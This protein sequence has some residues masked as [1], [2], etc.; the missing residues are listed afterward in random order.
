MKQ[1]WTQVLS[2]IQY[3]VIKIQHA[4][5]SGIIDFPTKYCLSTSAGSKCNFWNIHT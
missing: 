5:L 1:T 3:Q 4:S 2:K